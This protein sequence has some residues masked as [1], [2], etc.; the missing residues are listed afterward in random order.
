MKRMIGWIAVLAISAAFIPLPGLALGAGDDL[1]VASFEEVQAQAVASKGQRLSYGALPQQFGLLRVPANAGRHP[2]VVLIHG[3]CWL[4]DYDLSYM[5]GLAAALTARG[6]ATWN[7][8]FRRLGDEG[9]GWPGT[10]EDVRSALQ[11]LGTLAKQYSLDLSK[12]SVLGH[13][14]GGQLAL[15]LAA[16]SGQRNTGGGA[17]SNS[18]PIRTVVSLAGITDLQTYR[19][20]P[21]GSCHSA[22]DDLLGGSPSTQP[23]RYAGASPIE[24]LPLRVQQIIIQGSKDHV[25]AANSAVKYSEAARRAG[26]RVQLVTV[27][28]GHFDVVL[29][30]GPIFQALEKAL[31]QGLASP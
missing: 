4:A 9:G 19:K 8:E 20:G 30:S 25:V 24:R 1:S 13:S 7:I 18:V 27:D 3:G 14:S 5:E 15:W 10:F 22:V 11:F 28:G 6:F 2:V 12:V 21:P 31:A 29:A 26:D 16:E 17:R 23:A